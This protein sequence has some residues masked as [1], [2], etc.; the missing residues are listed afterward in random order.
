MSGVATILA[1]AV[2]SLPAFLA[3]AYVTGVAVGVFSS[4]QRAALAD[5][6]GSEARAG[7]AVAMFQM[8]SD[9]GAIVCSLVVGQIAEHLT[10]GWS[11]AVTGTVLLVAAAGWVMAPTVDHLKEF[12]GKALTGLPIP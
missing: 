10:F 9:L 3:A 6:L 7:T 8:V 2:T 1:S 4:A 5:I 12:V 11:F